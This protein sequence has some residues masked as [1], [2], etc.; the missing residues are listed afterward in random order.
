MEGEEEKEEAMNAYHVLHH[1]QGAQVQFAVS[2]WFAELQVLD[3]RQVNAT[4]L[5]PL[6]AAT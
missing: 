1:L 3:G 2:R 6:D 4:N 5:H